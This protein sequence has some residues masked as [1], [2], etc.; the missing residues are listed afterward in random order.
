MSMKKAKPT[1]TT[2]HPRIS[3]CENYSINHN[4]MKLKNPTSFSP[5]SAE[6]L[7]SLFSEKDQAGDLTFH[8]SD[9]DAVNAH[10][11]RH[12]DGDLRFDPIVAIEDVA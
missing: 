3:E 11:D 7:A 9:G 1:S 6:S 10:A 8:T 12:G 4:I 5:F 2:S